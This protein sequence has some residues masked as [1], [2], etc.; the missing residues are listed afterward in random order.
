MRAVDLRWINIF[1]FTFICL[2]CSLKS[3]GQFNKDSFKILHKSESYSKK[4]SAYLTFGE[5]I[6]K[7]HFDD[8][9]YI[10]NEGVLI[11]K[12]NGDSVAVGKLKRQ[13]GESYY[14]KG[15]YNEAAEYFYG[16]IEIFEK[17]NDQ[18]NLADSYNAL[19]KLYRKTKDLSR[20]LQN[21]DRAMSIFKS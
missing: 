21:Y 7:Q 17:L 10:A 6:G 15:S 13:I 19:A 8:V 18:K 5:K 3:T 14:F 4:I 9:I 20:S 1:V 11:A 12:K 2:F 16:S